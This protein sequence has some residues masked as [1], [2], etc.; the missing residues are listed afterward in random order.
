MSMREFDVVV[1]GAG[2]AGLNAA[3]T[4]ARHG[5]STLL[6]DSL[7][8]GGQIGTV[9]RIENFPGPSEGVAGYELGPML[10]I[11]ADEAGVEL[12]LDTVERV[13]ADGDGFIVTAS[14]GEFHA[15]AV[16]VAA[17]SV[18]RKLGV[19]G[20]EAFEG[21][22]VSHCASCDGPILR[23]RQVCVVGGGDSALDEA[24]SLAAHVA[25]VVI[26]HR[27]AEPTARRSLVDK[28]QAEEAIGFLAHTE[29]EAICGDVGVSHVRLRSAAGDVRD[30]PC[31]AVFV[32]VGL[33]PAA[34]F[35]GELVR[36]DGDG[37]IAVDLGMNA[38]RPGIFAAGDIR[39]QSVAHLAA[40]AGDGVTAAISAARY[41]RLGV[42]GDSTAAGSQ[43]QKDAI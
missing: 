14:E 4:A 18:R 23:G 6:V 25:K 35:L 43:L 19:E 3:T 36:R 8:A 5:L 7:G 28:C 13:A 33:E 42:K 21:K 38:S 12:M 10:Q 37:R 39:S 15:R 24:L 31:H 41:L 34:G 22:G 40:S 32:Y 26:V 30:L 11:Q 1:I 17:G 20:E 16:I 27:G 9:D 2:V 29:V